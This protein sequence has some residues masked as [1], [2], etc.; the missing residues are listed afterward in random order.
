[1]CRLKILSPKLCE[2]MKGH[3]TQHALLNLLNNWQKCFDKSEAA[4]TLFKS[5]QP[6]SDAAAV[7]YYEVMPTAANQ[8]K[9][10]SDSE[11]AV[12]SIKSD[13]PLS[14]EMGATSMKQD[15]SVEDTDVNI[16]YLKKMQRG[17]ILQLLDAMNL[18]IYK[19]AF[20]Q[21]HIDGEMMT[22]L[23][24]EMLSELGVSKALHRLRLMKIVSGQT[25]ASSY[26]SIS[27]LCNSPV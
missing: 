2:F 8:Q 10:S 13:Q 24:T 14:E 12:T 22:C 27:Q 25:S 17:D 18:S 1:M 16:A 4:G 7:D 3:S 23:S 6:P 9:T 5:D 20:E 11:A 19:E 26:I 15:G 21:E